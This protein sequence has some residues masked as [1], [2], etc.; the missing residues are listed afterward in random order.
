MNCFRYKLDHDYGFA[1]NPF[2]G[3]ITLDTCKGGIR[4]NKNLHIG[5]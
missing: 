5:D 3:V 2:H 1:P 4:K